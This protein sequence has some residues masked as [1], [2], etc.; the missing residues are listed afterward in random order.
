MRKQGRLFVIGLL[1]SFA[2]HAQVSVRILLGVG[3]SGPVRWDGTIA[4][5]GAKIASI[6]PWRFEG[7]D[8]VV[9]STW[10]L[11]THPIRLFGGGTQVSST[12]VSNVVA[13]GIIVNVAGPLSGELKITTAQGDFSIALD[14]L[15]YGKPLP[16]LNG[17]VLVDLIPA[18]VRLTNT[19]EE[20]D[21]PSAAAAKNGDVW[22][23]YV[24]FHHNP[25]HN[26]LRAALDT[27]PKDFTRWK[28]PTGG[29]QIFARKYSNGAWG[30]PIA[31][32][33]AGGDLYRSAIAIDGQGRPWVFWSQN[34]RPLGGR[35]NFD[36]FAKAIV[37]D[38]PGAPVQISNQPGSDIDPV[39]ATDAH[40]NVWVAW[41]G[42]RNGLAAI[43]AA[44]Q[45]G[46]KFG[47]PAAVS[48]SE[49]NEWDPAI[50]TDTTGRVTIA[51]D[52]YRN[53]NYDVYFRTATSGNWG[54]ET[55]AAATARYEAYPSIAY[56]RNG[57]LWVAYEEGG[58]GWGKDFGAY[59]TNGVAVYQG[60]LIRLR[61]FE[62]DGRAVEV[63]ADL[64]AVLP[65]FPNNQIE[66][67]GVQNDFAK[68]DPDPK[69][70][71]TREADRPARNM[72][73]ARNTLPRLTVDVS[74][75]IWLAFRSAHPIWWSALGTVWTEHLVSYDGKA[76]T[77]PI[78]LN[79]T[80]NL[81]DNRPALISTAPGQLLVIGSSDNRRQFQ[82]AENISSPLGI[83]A[84]SK[85]DPYN[86]DLYLNQIDLGPS[87]QPAALTA[88][89]PLEIAGPEVADKTDLGLVSLLRNYKFGSQT[90]LKIV[91]GEFHRHSEISMDGGFDGS[92]LDQYRYVL[93]AGALDWVGC[94]DHDNGAG[95]EYTWWISQKLT[96]IFYA[97]GKF[98]PMFSYERSV[99]Y[100]EGHRNVI[101][102]QRGVRT[103][104]RMPI[105]KED[106]TGHAPDTQNLYAYLKYFHGIAASHTS[107]T[108]MGTD[109]RDND[110]LAEPVVEI[111]QGDRQ[112]YEVPDGPRSNSEKD[113][114][115][116]WR[117]KGFVNLALQKG[118]KLGFQASSDHVSTHMSYCN[119]LA[120]DLTRES[121]LDA[122]EKRHVYG[123]T[124]NILA[125]VR[126]GPYI[127]GDAF[128]TAEAPNLH[129]KLEGTA[130]FAKVVV[131]K[132]NQ[133]VY[134]TQP[135]S[136]KVEFNWR[137]N[138]PVK[139]KTSYYYVRGE[140]NNGEIVWASP[141]WITYTGK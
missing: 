48:N 128:S 64:G 43:F 63:S 21:Y 84:T 103:L 33:P 92:I 39:A 95:R 74:G 19:T 127:M 51:W 67:A 6:E 13:N 42:W 89:R 85:V 30:K 40:G 49:G 36:I 4:A 52:S 77:R 25:E 100:P 26:A 73:N 124:D 125:D 2:L 78:Y 137:D 101:F 10:H 118:Y 46:L 50:A 112:N 44:S 17:R 31:I 18:S 106:Y 81:L 133:Y 91:R 113:S 116:N 134:S 114:I 97:P 109:W 11:S 1:A 82:L 41:Q 87:L 24:E 62:P 12:G 88:A 108:G 138:S 9:G 69:N 23:A 122:F 120:K 32:T 57:R 121:V 29:D 75:R 96:D 123:A 130:K 83:V 107:A 54:P 16:K 7:A 104:P 141:M 129:V 99:N 3:D 70:A 119:L 47:A 65:G 76:W 59:N 66:K 135:D 93:D 131:I 86:N 5:E 98:V 37:N 60:R 115:G 90:E 15:V 102:A 58:K 68:L 126:S 55:P 22:I 105:S 38:V 35:A 56:D 71:Q 111:Y 8:A 14:Q 136:D 45:N 80:D 72:N 28:S 132:D 117:P 27:A 94:C 20:E 140:Q 61:G 34:V 53:Q 110:P 139:G 79:H